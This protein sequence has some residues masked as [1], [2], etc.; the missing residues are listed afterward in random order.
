[1]YC[2]VRISKH[3]CDITVA[4]FAASVLL[5]VEETETGLNKETEAEQKTQ[6]NKWKKQKKKSK[7]HLSL[8]I[9]WSIARAVLF[10]YI[11]YC[12]RQSKEYVTR[13]LIVI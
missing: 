12:V 6:R 1:M 10:G 5:M 2:G 8:Q 9:F 11:M 3:L 13:Y 4:Y 7:K